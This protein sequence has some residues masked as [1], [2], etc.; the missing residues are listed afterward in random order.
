MDSADRN[1]SMRE[2]DGGV[3]KMGKRHLVPY[4]K[5]GF[6]FRILRYL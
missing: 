5:T 6:E 4:S 3:E 2:I 1:V